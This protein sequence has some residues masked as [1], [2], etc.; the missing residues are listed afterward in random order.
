MVFVL[1][2]VLCLTAHWPIPQVL[3]SLAGRRGGWGSIFWKTQDI[4]LASHSNNLSTGRGHGWIIHAAHVLT[5][6]IIQLLSPSRFSCFSSS[7]ILLRFASSHFVSLQI[8]AVSLPLQNNRKN[9]YFRFEA[10]CY[11]SHFPC[12]GSEPKTSSAHPECIAAI[13]LRILYT[14][15]KGSRLFAV[16]LFGSLHPPFVSFDIRQYQRKA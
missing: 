10:N 7:L 6:V 1:Y 15:R 4:G 11:L 13:F 5:Q 9:P 12:S 16:V 3:K 8:F 2:R 14:K